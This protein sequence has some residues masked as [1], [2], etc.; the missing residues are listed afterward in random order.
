MEKMLI[1]IAFIVSLL[2]QIIKYRVWAIQ[3]QEDDLCSELCGHLQVRASAI[4]F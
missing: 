3:D 2:N 1:F 4:H